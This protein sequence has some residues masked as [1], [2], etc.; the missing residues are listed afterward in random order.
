MGLTLLQSV[1]TF[2]PLA[3]V[4]MLATMLMG[5]WKGVAVSVI[6]QVIVAYLIMRLTKYVSRP[7]VEGP[8][9]AKKFSAVTDLIRR[10]GSWGYLLRAL[11]PSAVSTWSISRRGCSM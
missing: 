10:Y 2:I 11:S 9:E 5:F 8:S 1:I 3:V 6:T 4:M 7:L